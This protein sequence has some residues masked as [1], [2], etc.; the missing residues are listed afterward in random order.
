M[1]GTFAN[2]CAAPVLTLVCSATPLS[3]PNAPHTR[4][5]PGLPGWNP[6]ATNGGGKICLSFPS[7]NVL[8]LEHLCL[9]FWK[10]ASW[11]TNEQTCAGAKKSLANRI[12]RN[13]GTE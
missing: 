10:T 5:L 1:R 6:E 13:F 12:T 4:E 2:N 8:A 9:V 7:T 11:N 3:V